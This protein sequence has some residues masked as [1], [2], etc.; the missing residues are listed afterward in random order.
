MA[1]ELYLKAS[2]SMNDTVIKWFQD[3]LSVYS[4]ISLMHYAQPN[5]VVNYEV[6]AVLN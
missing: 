2:R 3:I 5:C 1:L 4:T 6:I